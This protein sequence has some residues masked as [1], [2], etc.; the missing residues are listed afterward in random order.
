MGW[1]GHGVGR[2]THDERGI[3]G[4][5]DAGQMA[6]WYVCAA[7]RFYPVDPTNPKFVEF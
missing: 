3:P 2:Y 7:L 4:N 1:F 5:D 6:A